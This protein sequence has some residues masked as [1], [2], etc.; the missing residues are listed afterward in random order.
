[1]EDLVAKDKAVALCA[2]ARRNT[3]KNIVDADA[4]VDLTE[5]L[6][7]SADVAEASA[8]LVEAAAGG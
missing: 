3:A 1:V 6:V 8:D 7:A 4:M 2:H 5:A